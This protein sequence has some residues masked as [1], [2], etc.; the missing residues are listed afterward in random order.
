MSNRDG[1]KTMKLYKSPYG[2]LLTKA[3]YIPSF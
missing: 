2:M 1:E 3:F